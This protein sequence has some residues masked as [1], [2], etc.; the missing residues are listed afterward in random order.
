MST[1]AE[2]VSEQRPEVIQGRLKLDAPWNRC[3]K[4]A[5]DD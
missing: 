1:A 3:R 4:V 2:S 5:S